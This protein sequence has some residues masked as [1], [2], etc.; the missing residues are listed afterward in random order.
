MLH[1]RSCI[2]I[3]DFPTRLFH[4]ALAICV[5]GAYVSVKLGGLYMDWH[6]RFGLATLG[7]IVFRVLWGLV[8]PRYARFSTF[9]RGPGAIKRYI[10]GAAT[11]AGHNPLG[12]LSVIAML[13][14][15]GF[16]TISGLFISDDI[17]TQGPLYGRIDESV[18][19]WLA[20]WHE[21]NEWIIIGLV[22]LHFVAIIWYVAVRRRRI[23]GPMITGNARPQDLPAGT[24]P[25]EDGPMIWL[26]AA[27]IAAAV[28]ALVLWIR[29]LELV[30]D[31]SFS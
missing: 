31:F 7:L 9:V 25:T 24:P 15:L 8:G 18:S 30:A 28:T 3:W 19:S 29:S 1:T 21:R 20:S 16:Q 10:Q 4:W 22:V 6:V 5:I 12:A 27:I 11:S 2:R 17:M 26:R 23:V 14:V 13:A